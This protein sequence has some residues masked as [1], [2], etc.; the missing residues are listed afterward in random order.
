MK[1]DSRR[2]RQAVV[3][4]RPAGRGSL[5]VGQRMHRTPPGDRCASDYFLAAISRGKSPVSKAGCLSA[6]SLSG[7]T[8]SWH[9][10]SSVAWLISPVQK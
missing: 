6:I 3:H 1:G 2:H 8:A 4:G 10:H 5:A 9:V 7:N